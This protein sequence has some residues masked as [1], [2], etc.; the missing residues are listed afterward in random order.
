[1]TRST[2]R[3]SQP[4]ALPPIFDGARASQYA[5]RPDASQ[6]ATTA[7]AW[8]AQHAIKPSA[9]DET[10][11]HLLL[12]DVQKDFCFP[13]GSLY[14]AGRSGTGA[15]DDSRRI[16]ELV[17][18]N[19]NVITEI[20]TTLDTHLAYQIFFPSFWLDRDDA[21]LTAHRVV[22]SEQI[23]AGEARPNPAMAKWLCG[24][25]YTWLCKQA[26]HYTKELEKAGKYQ[27]YLWP[28]HCLLGSDGHALAGIVHE[29]RLFHAFAR[30]SQSN[31]EVKGGNPLTENYSVLRPE[32]LSRFDGAALAQRNTGFVQTLL[33]ADAVV[34]AG[35]AASHCVKSTI[36]DLLDEIAAH[37][38]AL[39]KKVYLVTDCMSSVTVPDGKGGFAVDFSAQA[40]QALAKFANAGMHLVRS[41]D[42][43]ASW[44]GIKL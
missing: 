23:A 11:V 33:A 14:V 18:R 32:V 12:I 44:P 26:L 15:I 2:T 42:P 35:Q 41:T 36:D 16:A 39:A 40:D 37:D 27:L 7:T 8:R 3:P 43:I 24:G 31:V 5:Y 28:P 19:L 4:L 21:P 1:M 22:T 10:R 30:T 6:L 20:T 25:N 38:P 9:S 13:E 29:A 17:Y 34:I